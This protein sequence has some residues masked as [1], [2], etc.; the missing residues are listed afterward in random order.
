LRVLVIGGGGREHAI[1]RALT[2]SAHSPEL[3]C[4][5]GNAGIAAD[6]ECLPEVAADDVE[7]IVAAAVER[8]VDLVAIGPEAA[9][10]A[11]AVDALGDAGVPAFGPAAAAAEVEGSKAFAKELMREAGVPTASH[12]LLRNEQEAVEQVARASYPAVLKADGLAAGKGVIVC[13][14]EQEAREA[15]DVFFTERRFGEDMPVVFEEFLEGEELSMLAVCDGENAVPL[16]PAQ[17]YKRIFDGDRGPNTGGMGSYSPVPGFGP[18]DVERIV[19]AVHR[20]VLEA[21]AGRG[22]PFHGVL[23]AGLMIGGDGEP[24]VLEFN[25]RFGDPET[26]AVLPRL[27]SDLVDLMLGAREPGGLAGVRA[28]FDDDWAVTLVLATDGY[29]RSSSKGDRIEGLEE[30]AELAEITH[31][32][33]AAEDGALVTAGG[34]VLNVTGLGPTPA[35]ARARAY[36]AAKRISFDGMQ[37]RTDIAARAAERVPG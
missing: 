13:A 36:D 12:L 9:L 22:T 37:M 11:G 19:D 25:A 23:Y 24:R 27:R 33:T 15:V 35:D 18:E 10:V 21:M 28:E 26:Q 17:D 8:R 32:G 5:P 16:A 14:S 1:V 7:A 2:R 3:L 20:P 31:A 29:P 6:A 34:R 30:A 4:A